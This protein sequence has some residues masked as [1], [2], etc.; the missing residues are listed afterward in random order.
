MAGHERRTVRAQPY[1]RARDLFRCAEAFHRL[2]LR[3]LIQDVRPLCVCG[4]ALAFAA[5]AQPHE[6]DAEG[7]AYHSRDQRDVLLSFFSTGGTLSNHKRDGRLQL[8]TIRLEN[9]TTPS[10]SRQGR[11]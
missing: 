4:C 6:G 5:R 3:E 1:H 11:A 9:V 2:V 7:G 8:S 10:A